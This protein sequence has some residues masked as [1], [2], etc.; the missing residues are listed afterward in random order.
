MC[1]KEREGGGDGGRKSRR[2]GKI[3]A[4]SS[5]DERGRGIESLLYALNSPPS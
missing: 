1:R 3:E 2:G 4:G 5:K